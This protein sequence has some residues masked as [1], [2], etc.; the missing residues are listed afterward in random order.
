MNV[1][2]K[3]KI[4][5][6]DDQPDNLLALE[7]IFDDPELLLVR[8]YSG[9]E[10]L[11][12]LFNEEFAV[13][14]LDASMPEMDGFET[15]KIIRSREKT[16]S[17]PIIFLSAMHRDSLHAAAGYNSGA[18]DY[19]SKPLVP[20]ILKA[21]V[22]VFVELFKK[23]K[24]I[25]QQAKSLESYKFELENSLKQI[26]ETN[27]ELRQLSQ[28]ADLAREEA[29]SSSRF[30]SEFL[31]NMSHEVRTPMNGILGMIEIL[32][33]SGLTDVQM[34]YA[35]TAKEAGRSLI[36]VINDILDL[37]KIE[38]GKLT[39]ES[40]PFDPVDLIEG[41][42][43]LLAPQADKKNLALLTFIADDVPS[44]VLGDQ[45]RIRQIIT[46]L[47]GNALKFSESGEIVIRAT[48]KQR[49]ATLIRVNFSVSDRG[50]GLTEHEIAEVFK[51]FV[52]PSAG[53]KY[54]GTGLGLSISKNLAELMGGELTVESVKDRG[55]TFTLSIPLEDL[56]MHR[57][58]NDASSIRFPSKLRILLVCD[59]PVSSEILHTYFQAWGISSENASTCKQ[60]KDRLWQA[61][62]E[63]NPYDILVADFAETD[64]SCADLLDVVKSSTRLKNTKLIL[65]KGINSK[66]HYK[67]LEGFDVQLVKPVRQSLLLD[68]I[69]TVID[70]TELMQSL[71]QSLA[72]EPARD[73]TSA[74]KILVVEDQEINQ[75]IAQMFLRNLGFK[76]DL[77]TNGSRA[78]EI[79]N[80]SKYD[81]IFMDCQMP[82]LDGFMTT[83]Q[84]RLNEQNTK[85]HVPIVAMTAHAI[86][87]SRDKCLNAGMDDYI[88]KPISSEE[89]KRILEKWL[90]PPKADLATAE[91]HGDMRPLDLESLSERYG[92]DGMT[93]MVPLYMAD[94][95]RKIQQIQSAV[96][97]KDNSKLAALVHALIGNS[98]AIFAE[99][100]KQLCVLIERCCRAEDWDMVAANVE[101]LLSEM[102][103][104]DEFV[105][106]NDMSSS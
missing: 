83:Q 31:A 61:L 39:L 14:L 76:C 43:S 44:V 64:N 15:A 54:G 19:L 34:Q 28:R 41:I 37:S 67:A 16:R 75:Q 6:V 32:I 51:P 101:L 47:A 20:E 105:S 33:Q 85:D 63:N 78:L 9:Q 73:V 40:M 11:K 10:A 2:H 48:L 94:L 58:A 50:I 62:D 95:P 65:I 35:K 4:L 52:Q 53:G 13:I 36:T 72:A 99:R 38:A 8:A 26:R 22:Y 57:E 81:L 17:T 27:E 92:S 42:A 79:L 84:I 55:S 80:H 89:L 90:S 69:Y 86:E 18:V 82:E 77:A 21:K 45:V 68:A 23:T 98:A 97:E 46:N 74:K 3:I 106:S 102:H 1:E 96:A 5:A 60:A 29:L 91:A 59:E 104:L 24:E 87:G 93:R 70:N 103:K 88:S 30:K 7:T 66:F 71:E 25:Q 56:S 12:C 100:I 49:T